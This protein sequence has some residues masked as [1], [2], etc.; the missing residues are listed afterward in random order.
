MCACVSVVPLRLPLLVLPRLARCDVEYMD[1]SR[2]MAGSCT[3]PCFAPACVLV[4]GS[5]PCLVALVLAEG[6][7]RSLAWA[8][9]DGAVGAPPAPAL[10]PAAGQLPLEDVLSQLRGLPSSWTAFVLRPCVRMVLGPRRGEAMVQIFRLCAAAAA[11]RR[12]R[13]ACWLSSQ[14]AQLRRLRPRPPLTALCRGRQSLCVCCCRARPALGRRTGREEIE[15]G[16]DNNDARRQGE[17]G[18]ARAR[19]GQPGARWQQRS[20]DLRARA[21]PT[22]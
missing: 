6:S 8:G 13:R 18:L 16:A 5:W 4:C 20:R 14:P 1:F 17:G 19:R 7:N 21:C 12:G 15:A 11:S 9:A 3:S 10:A 2:R 22:R